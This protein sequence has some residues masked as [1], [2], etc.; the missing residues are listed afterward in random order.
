MTISPQVKHGITLSP[1]NSIPKLYT[2]KIENKCSNNDTH[3]N[4]HSSS[5]HKNQK[6]KTTQMSI[7]ER[8]NKQ[9]VAYPTMEYYT[10]VKRNEVPIHAT[11]WMN[12]E[13]I[14]LN[15]RSQIQKTT[16]YMT[17]SI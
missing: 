6:V 13:N 10:V 17:P 5:V 7:D 1:S 2:K 8:I 9:N 11:I 12:P 16:Y 14:T 3:I 15:E 4:V